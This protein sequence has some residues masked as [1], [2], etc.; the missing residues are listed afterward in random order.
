MPGRARAVL[1]AGLGSALALAALAAPRMA[2]GEDR[3]PPDG[4]P[5]TAQAGDVAAIASPSAR[6]ELAPL[7]AP[8]FPDRV[9]RSPRLARALLEEAAIMATVYAVYVAQPLPAPGAKQFSLLDKLR[10]EPGSFALDADDIPTNYVGHPVAGM[11]Y[12]QIAR[13]N[14]LDVPTSAVFAAASGL[15]WEL[16]EFKEPASVNDAVSTAV[17]G[18]ALGEAF[19]QLGACLE[20]R[21]GTVGRFLALVANQPKWVNDRIDGASSEPGPRRGWDRLAISIAGGEVRGS[22]GTS[23]QLRFG[24][25]SRIV[26]VTEYGQ[27]GRSWQALADGEVSALGLELAWGHQGI[28]EVE[29][30]AEASLAGAYARD[31]DEDGRGHDLLATVSAGWDYGRRSESP[32]GGEPYDYLVLLRLPSVALRHRTLLDEARLEVGIEAAVSFGAVQPFAL[33]GRP[34][35]LPGVPGVVAQQ[36]YYHGLGFMAAP[37]LAVEA[38]AVTAA[39]TARLDRLWG[40]VGGDVTGQ[41]DGKARLEDQRADLD[42]TAA[43]R[44]PWRGLEL[45]VAWQRHARWGRA[46]D[47]VAQQAESRL[48]VRFESVL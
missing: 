17:G 38:G 33:L 16:L 27:A 4:T 21:G 8:T 43:W 23:S 5:A 28:S 15:A 42:V 30:L 36:G 45:G 1:R 41:S 25:G 18:V 35:D 47:L 2:A 26:R 19:T 29:L 40:L 31:V 3:A 32:A 22:G 7:Q 6:G 20:R 48:L 46:D 10:L 39:A 44:S 12:Y 14:R 13:G 34:P 11:Y 9:P 37:R 24:A